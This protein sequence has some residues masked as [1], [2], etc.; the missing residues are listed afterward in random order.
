MAGGLFGLPFFV[1]PKCII[2]SLLLMIAYWKLPIKNHNVYKYY[3]PIVTT[4]AILLY[5]VL[6][7]CKNQSTITLLTII[8]VATLLLQYIYWNLERDLYAAYYFIFF[9]GYVSL[10]YFDYLMECSIPLGVGWLSF[11]H[12]FKLH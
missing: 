10:A 4:L 2:F 5:Y 12:L 7:V 3:I 11:T 8:A 9:F 6:Y 1:N